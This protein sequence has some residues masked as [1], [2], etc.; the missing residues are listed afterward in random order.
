MPEWIRPILLISL[1]KLDAAS[2]LTHF[3]EDISGPEP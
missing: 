2:A 3:F 1:D